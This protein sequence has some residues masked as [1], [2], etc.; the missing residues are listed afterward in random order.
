MI[1]VKEAPNRFP[2]D[3]NTLFV[4]K[5]HRLFTLEWS[6]WEN[7]WYC[8]DLPRIPRQLFKTKEEIESYFE[9]VSEFV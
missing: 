8:P 4:E 1:E 9:T 3:P 2:F 5:G 6:E 7:G